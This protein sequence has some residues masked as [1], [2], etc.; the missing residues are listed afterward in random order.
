MN[1]Y[2]H[3]I[4]MISE[5]TE[6]EMRDRALYD[7]I[8]ERIKTDRFSQSA[9]YKELWFLCDVSFNR[10]QEWI[11]KACK[12]LEYHK[13]TPVPGETIIDFLLAGKRQ[14]KE[15]RKNGLKLW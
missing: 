15:D 6:A 5:Q 1:Y 3:Y 11:L 7:Y 10:G 14:M 12:T 13:I 4:N 9:K 2:Q 8:I